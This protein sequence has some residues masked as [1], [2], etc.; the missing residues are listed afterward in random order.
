MRP[1]LAA[2]AAALL[3]LSSPLSAQPGPNHLRRSYDALESCTTVVATVLTHAPNR[4]RTF[5][6][7]RAAVTLRD[8]L[9]GTPVEEVTLA[10]EAEQDGDAEA[11]AF[12]SE[13]DLVL[14]GDDSLRL[15]YPARIGRSWPAR[16]LPG[17]T[18]DQAYV[19]VPAADLARLARAERVRGSAGTRPF[20]LRPGDLAALRQL[21]DFVAR[22]PRAPVPRWA[23]HE[24]PDCIT[25][26]QRPIRSGL[27]EPGAAPP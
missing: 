7:L 17:G 3:L 15:R 25:L 26:D 2:A 1:V 24:L 27:A 4:A 10:L 20:A 8:S 9:R 6:S 18:L 14:E 13:P 12:G 21:A 22:S 19:K 11:L 23:R 5:F 16:Y